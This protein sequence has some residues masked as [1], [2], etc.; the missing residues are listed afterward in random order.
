MQQDTPLRL[1]Q[2]QHDDMLKM[3]TNV[4]AFLGGH[5]LNLRA[6]L[7]WRDRVY[8]RETDWTAD[9]LK[10]RWA[11]YWGDAKKM[12]NPVVP[13]VQPQVEAT[14]GY[15]TEVFCTGEP[16]FG[17]VAP[18]AQVDAGL[19]MES[20]IGDNSRRFGWRAE[21][22][23][24][25]RDGLKYNLM[26]MEKAWERKKVFSIIN[27]PSMREDA[28]GKEAEE[29]Y[30]GNFAKR[31]DLY[32]MIL[33]TR[34]L[35]NKI[36]SDGEF[37]GYV[38]LYP[39]TKLKQ[40]IIDLGPNTTMNVTDAFK[41][42]CNSY[43]VGNNTAGEYYIPLVNPLALL[44]PSSNYGTN[45]TSWLAGI[46]N[47]GSLEYKGLYEV[48]TIY[49]RFLPNDFNLNLPA[50]NT[51]QIFKLIVVNKRWIIYCK[52][53]TNAHNFLPIVVGQPFDDG[54]GYQAKSFGD[55]VTPYQEMA[56]SLWAAGIE[57][58]RRLVFDR[59][60]YDPSR[61]SKTDID[62]TSSVARI[63]VKPGAYGKPVGD[64]V[65]ASNYRDDSVVGI[66]EMAQRVQQMAQIANGTNNVQQGQFQKGNKTK[67]EFE[68]VMNKSDWHPRLLAITL[69]DSWFAPLKEITKMNII[70]YQG[71]AELYNFAQQKS[72]QVNP[73]DLRRA[74]L[75]FKLTDGQTPS[76]KLLSMDLMGQVAQ[77]GMAIPQ[78]NAQYDIIGMLLYSFK[79]QGAYWL[80]NFKRTP[81]QQQQFLKTTQ[82]TAN[83][84]EPV[85]K[86]DPNVQPQLPAPQ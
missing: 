47:N 75:Q 48:A 60:F 79:S 26:A 13:V 10:A 38:E 73:Q 4:Y 52:R 82:A 80:D 29:M 78:I 28:A 40:L 51:P 18:P 22:V 19:Q 50:K 45:W 20:V 14:V 56:S 53:M 31:I 17:V 36:H 2:K 49:A 71:Q 32:N 21:Y 70:Q 86:K 16:F 3:V 77:L 42:D 15:L 54:L 46:N 83:A 57:S 44:S 65:F 76:E 41:S 27:D 85:P 68:T 39:R 69:E 64:A 43:T 55:N 7:E 12:Q 62:R 6:G 67:Y 11:N 34:V 72:V 30:A 63:P 35:P 66:L 23:K 24:C 25:F 58:K 33:D 74:V 61:I 84:Q 5:D 59:L 81:E 37:V 8:Y 9:Q 1:S